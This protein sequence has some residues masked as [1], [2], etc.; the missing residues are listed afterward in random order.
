[1]AEQYP[2]PLPEAIQ[3]E[4]DEVIDRLGPHPG[5]YLCY[6]PNSNPQCL[7]AFDN[8]L[9]KLSMTLTSLDLACEKLESQLGVEHNRELN[10]LG[11]VYEALEAE[12]NRMEY[13]LKWGWLTWQYDPQIRSAFKPDS[14]AGDEA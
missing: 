5:S 8:C 6:P 7:N 1:M 14:A 4:A 2:F 11:T 3:K 9:L 10:L 13:L 12:L